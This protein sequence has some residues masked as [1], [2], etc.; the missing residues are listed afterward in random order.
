MAFQ[1]QGPMIPQTS[2]RPGVSR[3]ALAIILAS[4]IF[5][6]ALGIITW[7][8]MHREERLMSTFLRDE[9]LTLI[10]A[11]E[12]GSRTA[13]MMNMPGDSL[14]TLVKETASEGAIAYVAIA[15]ASGRVLTEAGPW[16]PGEKVPVARILRAK[17]TYTRL[18]RDAKGRAVYE[19]AR[20][21]RPLDTILTRSQGA[22]GSRQGTGMSAMM[23]GK[24][25]K[26]CGSSCT[27][28][29]GGEKRVI[30]VGLYTAA[31]EADHRQDLRQS[32][33]VGAVLLLLGSAGFYFLL[34]SQHARVARRTLA[35]MELYTR[36]VIESIPAGL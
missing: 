31:F 33:L 17:Q 3:P 35:N 25:R 9:G 5:A 10:H 11:F 22:T 29:N 12:A 16:P 7:R 19:V 4:V 24:W 20:E 23:Q 2:S 30:V 21:F 15:D 8:N 34:V 1:E 27:L 18:C 36:N 32:M 13:M 14:P 6:V 26:W 28:E